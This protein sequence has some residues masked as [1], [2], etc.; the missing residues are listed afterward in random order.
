M[1]RRTD[2]RGRKLS[3]LDRDALTRAI[4]ITRDSSAPGRREQVDQMMEER[5]W[6]SAALF[7]VYSCQFDAIKPRLWQP[8]PHDITD[9][10]GTLAKGDDGLGGKYAAAKLLRRMLRAGLSKYEPEP[11]KKLAETPSSMVSPA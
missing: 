11:L 10:E 2:D 4:A 1:T 9:L 7:C 3:P 8:T 5:G 6:F